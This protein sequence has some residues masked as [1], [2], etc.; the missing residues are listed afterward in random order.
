[1]I[2]APAAVADQIGDEGDG[3]YGGVQLEL[4]PPGRVQAVDARTVEHVAAMAAFG[5]EAEIVDVRRGAVLEYADQLVLRAIEGALPGIGF[6]PDQQVLPLGVDWPGR[7]Q[8]FGEVT[9]IHKNEMDR[10]ILTLSNGKPDEAF[11]EGRKRCLG[12]LS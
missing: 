2:V 8:E 12:H 6:V 10:T 9:P 5:A 11:E 3:L 7:L 4:A 1:M